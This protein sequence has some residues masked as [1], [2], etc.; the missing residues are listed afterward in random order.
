[1][2]EVFDWLKPSPLWQ[3]DGLFFRQPDF[4]RPMLLEFQSDDFMDKFFEAAGAAQPKALEE[5]A[6]EP[7]ENGELLKLFQP[8]HARYYLVCASL[9]CRLNGFP[10]RMV[11]LADGESVFFL[12]RK[13]ADGEEYGWVATEDGQKYWKSLQ[14]TPRRVLDDEERYPMAQTRAGNDRNVLFGYLPTASRETNAAV[15]SELPNASGIDPRIAELQA[16]FFRPLAMLEGA[17]T[18]TA[19]RLSVYL[20]LDLWE[21][22]YTYLREVA[23]ALRDDG[24]A[25]LEGAAGE[26]LDALGD[27]ALGGT[28]TLKQAL[29]EVAKQRDLLNDL[30]DDALPAQFRQTG[31]GYIYSLRRRTLATTQI[32]NAVDKALGESDAALEA[33]EPSVLL[34]KFEPNTGDQYVV[35]C[36]YERPQCDPR[37]EWISHRSSEFQLAPLFDPDAP[38]RP[39]RIALP[40]DVSI[41]GLRKFQKGV[42][43]AVSNSLRNKIAS[44]RGAD[45]SMMD[46]GQDLSDLS[47]GYLCTFSIPIITIC[48]FILLLVMVMV[49][50]FVFWWLPFFKIC[51]PILQPSD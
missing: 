44:I 25:T 29:T 23:V 15:V 6:L 50:N 21:Y 9:C 46:D 47:L 48:A 42:A 14:G 10:D 24:A 4:F 22:L 49:L 26:L 33:K 2:P 5:C 17:D 12:L 8:I 39:I 43:F 35:R 45:V 51:L 16:R 31:V 1:M 28:L 30:G 18:S 7:D 40:T 19:L 38:A 3:E 11:R 32:T 13:R 34:P 20:L 27:Q 41:A 36:V 37:Q